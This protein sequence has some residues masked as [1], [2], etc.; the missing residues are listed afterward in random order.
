MPPSTDPAKPGV[1][2]FG[3]LTATQ[4]K[5]KRASLREQNLIFDPSNRVIKRASVVDNYEP[6][7]IDAAP[8]MLA[9]ATPKSKRPNRNADVVEQL[10]FNV[11][12]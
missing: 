2:T 12:G 8:H 1:H 5:A 11:T 4:W 6:P 7:T 9:S 10:S 3:F